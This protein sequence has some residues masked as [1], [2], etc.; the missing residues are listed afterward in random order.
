LGAGRGAD[1]AQEA[2]EH[3]D[4]S[5]TSTYYGSEANWYRQQLPLLW[6]NGLPELRV[7]DAQLLLF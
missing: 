3:S 1:L 4:A 2:L 5:I 6:P 7:R